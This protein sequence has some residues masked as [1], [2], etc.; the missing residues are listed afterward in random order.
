MPPR[1]RRLALAAALSSPALTAH[2]DSGTISIGAPLALTGD[3]SDV[4]LQEEQG[5]DIAVAAINAKGGV[6]VGGKQEKL[7]LVKYDYQSQTGQAMQLMQRLITVDKVN[8]LL[9]PFGSGDTKAT[10]AIAERYGIPMI[11]SSAAATAIYNQ[12]YKNL[13]GVLFTSKAISTA[14]V[15]YI[16]AHVP[17]TH[18]VAILAMNSLY[19]KSIA[20]NLDEAAIKGGMKIVFNGT[21]DATATDFSDSL[22]QIAALKPDWVYVSGYTQDLILVRQQMAELKIKVP[23]LTMTAGPAYPEFRKNLGA[24]ANNVVTDSWWYYTAKYEDP[25][26]FGS[27]EGYAAAFNKKYGREPSYLEAAASASIEV[28]AEAIEA[29]GT[30]DP[31]AVREKLA[32]M[33]FST[34]YGPIKFGADGQNTITNP[35]LMQIQ[36]GKIVILSPPS[37]AQGNF[38]PAE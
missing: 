31:T 20:E 23:V 32:S 15:A 21:Y 10:A 24:L 26:I 17:A 6:K 9:A 16:H 37:L 35:V 19:P 33:S 1:P 4:G 28:L 34:F 13:F 7:S 18:T 3:L 30:T 22:T 36:N 27:A 2:A 5:F 11:A 29:A 8:F 12:N 25:Y 14:E 38:M